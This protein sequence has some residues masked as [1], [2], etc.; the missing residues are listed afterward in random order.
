MFDALRIGFDAPKAS[1]QR[2][3][4]PPL[5]AGNLGICGKSNISLPVKPFLANNLRL[6]LQVPFPQPVTGSAERIY[7]REKMLKI[8]RAANGGVVFTVSG[9]L[10]A[11]NLAELKTLF[12]S[13]VGGCHI[14]LDLKELTQVDQAAV[15]FLMRCESNDI[16]LK[17]CTAY[18]REWITRE[19]GQS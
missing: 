8:T 19:R 7:R 15:S 13:E 5:V 2:L 16:Q 17:N 9:R 18:I 14:T 1:P 10:D 4:I 12:R 6:E 11:G 3:L